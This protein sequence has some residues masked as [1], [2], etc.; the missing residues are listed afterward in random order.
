MHPTCEEKLSGVFGV[1]NLMIA[2]FIL[3][4]V[5]YFGGTSIEGDAAQRLLN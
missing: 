4:S 1:A 2:I 5:Y 3:Q